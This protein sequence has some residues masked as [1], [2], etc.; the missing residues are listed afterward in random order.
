MKPDPSHYDNPNRLPGESAE[1]HY[2]R[3]HPESYAQTA[4]DVDLCMRLSDMPCSGD[5]CDEGKPC[6]R[7]RLTSGIAA[8]YL[9]RKGRKRG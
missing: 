2:L 6:T 9:R 5:G 4:R 3:R 7:H 1:Q 8:R